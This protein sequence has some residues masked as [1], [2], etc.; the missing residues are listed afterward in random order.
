MCQVVNFFLF[1]LLGL[2]RA[3]ESVPGC[4][5]STVDKSHITFPSLLLLEFKSHT[6]SL[7]FNLSS[8]N[9]ILFFFL[10]SEHLP[11]KYLP[12]H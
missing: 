2:C 10:N 7:P 5:S 11:L 12:V 9:F 1:V 8:K 3:F 4:F 6:S